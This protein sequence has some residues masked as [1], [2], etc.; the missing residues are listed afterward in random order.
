MQRGAEH[1]LL[2]KTKHPP[3]TIDINI[4]FLFFRLRILLCLCRVIC[5]S[6]FLLRKRLTLARPASAVCLTVGKAIKIAR[7]NVLQRT[8]NNTGK[9]RKGEKISRSVA[10]SEN[11]RSVL[12]P[13]PIP[14][15][16]VNGS[17]FSVEARHG[18]HLEYAIEEKEEEGEERGL[19]FY[20]ARRKKRRE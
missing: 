3:T 16:Y 8:V 10:S 9:K 14:I 17:L 7:K 13:F 18:A 2:L 6:S 20:A 4:L 5:V 15:N 19:V 11:S 12:N 1:I